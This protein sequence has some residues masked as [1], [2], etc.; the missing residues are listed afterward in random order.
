MKD[1]PENTS[2]MVLNANFS[3]DQFMNMTNPIYADDLKISSLY[4]YD[5]KDKDDDSEISSNELSLVNRGGSWGTNQE[6]RVTKPITQFENQPVV[7]IYPVPERYSFWG[8]AINQNSTSMDY[9]LSASYFQKTNWNEIII[10]KQTIVISP[11][12]TVEIDAELSTQKEQKTGIYDGFLKFEGEHH[13]VN[14]PV[15]YVIVEKIQKDIPFIFVGSD[16]DVNFGNEYVKGAFDMTNRYMAG[17]WR[18]FY[19]DIEDNTI[20]SASFELSWK[21]DNSNFSAFV[22]DPQGKIIGTNMP[23]GVFG[24]FMNWASLDWL[25]NS[26]FS[27]GGGF[28]P[29]KNKDN[30]STL[31]FAPINQT[32]TH[33]LL[34]HSTLFEGTTITEPV[35][36]VGKFTTLTADQKAPEIILEL[37][38]FLKSDYVIIPEI[39]EDNPSS[40]VYTLNGNII[41]INDFGIDVST[42]DDN[43]YTLIINAIDKFGLQSSQTFE[44]VVDKT[45]PTVELLSNN[46]TVVSKRLD[47]QVS[48]SDQNLPESNYLSYLLPNGERIVDK[49]SHSFDTS[50]L[51]EGKYLIDIFAKDEAENIMSS[52]IMFEIDHSITDLP[53]SQTDISSQ[54]TES[55]IDYL[56]IIIIGI[57]ATAIV[58]VLVILKQKSKIPQKN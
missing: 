15:S 51:K 55:S 50:D 27:Q 30:T 26:P 43:S 36:L 35:T 4:L 6:L 1:I 23:T 47:I 41:E 16:G 38:E 52:K 39:I 31:I 28:F 9:T 20:N 32:G 40:V 29:V 46:N 21:N 2:L 33:S 11:N 3:F 37:D 34:I 48:I 45:L 22:L 56:S 5:W 14:V 54:I 17:D 12:Q 44:F 58:S 53:K 8:G 25:G 19:I 13:T 49:K 42:L 10:D 18:Q 57:I 24:H 7:G